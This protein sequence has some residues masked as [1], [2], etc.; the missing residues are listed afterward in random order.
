VERARQ[1]PGVS[2][3]GAAAD[4]G[5]RARA[6]RIAGSSPAEAVGFGLAW[7]VLI[8]I[9]VQLVAT[10]V[11][12]VSHDWWPAYDTNAYWLAA[13]HLLDGSPLYQQAEIT[14]S[15]AYKYPPILAQ[16]IIP[17]GLLPEWIVDWTWRVTGVAC[18]RYL[19]GSWKFAVIAALQ[20]PVMTELSFGNVTLQ[21]GAVALACFG[22]GRT[23]TA[24][25][26]LLPWLGAAKVGPALLIA[27]L[28]VTRPETRR[29]LAAGCA[30]F[31]AACAVSVAAAPGL[32]FDYAGTFGWE[33]SSRMDA[34]FVV[35]IVPDHGGLDFA[36]RL[37]I[38]LALL[39]AAVRWRLDWLA[40]V[41]AAA[42]MPI[43]SLTRLAVLVGLWPLR[44]RDLAVRWRAEGSGPAR[45]L[46]SPLA[47]LDMLPR[48]E[49]TAARAEPGRSTVSP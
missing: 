29:T 4:R 5:V 39:I 49:P 3:A 36:I 1:Q 42:M 43:L 37:A 21:L 9:A 44:L 6:G 15:G 8:A 35:A 17:I 28:L 25:L 11:E 14:T 32:W 30:L 16:A 46:T 34:W 22:R 12:N 27:Y 2:P 19:C 23:A 20:W 41:V 47:A 13:R 24:G 45:W 48:T 7:F 31:A 33:A 18:L 38:A 26:L 40:F 10:V